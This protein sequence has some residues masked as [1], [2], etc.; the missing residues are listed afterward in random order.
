MTIVREAIFGAFFRSHSTAAAGQTASRMR[1]HSAIVPSV[2]SSS[3]AP[4]MTANDSTSRSISCAS[5]RSPE[6]W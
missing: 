4:L 1:S 6:A 3:T 5:T 2:S